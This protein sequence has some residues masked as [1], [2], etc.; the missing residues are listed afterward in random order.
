MRSAAIALL[1]LAIPFSAQAQSN[2]LVRFIGC[3]IYRD[4]DF[5]RKSG[6]WLVDDR[7]SGRR[8]DI[9]LSPH[10]PDWNFEVLVE[11]RISDA[12]TDAC[13]ATVL[14]PVRASI[15]P[16]PCPRHMLPAE[17]HPGRQFVRPARTVQPLTA[18]RA[19]PAGPY[20]GRTFALFF[21]FDRAF[22]TYQYGDYL[23]DQASAWIDAA[24][25]RAV[26]VT[27]FAATQRETVSGQ[28]IAERP[29][30]ARERADAVALALRRLHPDLAIETRVR[31]NAEPIDH[32][33]SD[34]L[35]DQSRR[36]VEIQA[37]F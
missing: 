34:T 4:T 26:I 2:Q 21:E 35:P 16:R 25:P 11:G 17:A 13:G 37:V 7:E 28:V 15:L 36:R 6:C 10:N 3:P 8:Y 19:A 32:P 24:Q 22:I 20:E 14:T 12:P 5:G 1:A 27:G 33:D 18:T 9:S 30:V 23:L 31:R 29:E